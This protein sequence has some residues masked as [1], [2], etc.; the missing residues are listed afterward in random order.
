MDNLNKELEDVLKNA[1]KSIE[2][3]NKSISNVDLGSLSEKQREIVSK[4]MD[5]SYL[6]LKDPDKLIEKQKELSEM[7]KD[8]G[9]GN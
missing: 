5:T 7:I 4:A 8:L 9:N 1:E 3:V 2:L 6:K